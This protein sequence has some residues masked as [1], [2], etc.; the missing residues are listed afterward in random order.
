MMTPPLE[1]LV[2]RRFLFALAALTSLAA[3]GKKTEN[4]VAIQT[5]PVVRRDIVVDATATATI[6]PINIVEVKSKTASG[7]ITQMT[8]EVGSNVRPGDLIVQIDTR[9]LTNAANQ[10]QADFEAAQAK[11]NTSTA[12]KK[13]SD[14][15]FK[16][17]IITAQE[18]E[19]ANLDFA[20]SQA[21]FVRARTSLDL[22]QQRL[23][24][25]TVRAPVVGT[26]IE[27]TVSLGQVIQ[28]GTTSMGGGSTIL[29]MADLSRV[30]ARAL[31]NETDIGQIVAGQEATVTVDAFPDRPF[32]GRVEKV[33]PQAVVQQNVTMFPVLISLSN[34]EGLLKPGMNGEAAVLVDRRTDVL[35]IPNDAVRSMREVQTIAPL[36]NL[37]PDSVG[38]QLR[39]SMGAM[40]GGGRGG[41]GGARPAQG[42]RPQT[43]NGAVDLL[44]Q[45]FGGQGGGGFQ[46][47]EVTDADCKKVDD[48]LKK[49]PAVAKQL[50]ALREQMRNPDA[51]RRA[52]F[53]QT[54]E[55]YTKLGVDA[56]VAGACRRREGGSG[57][58][59]GGGAMAGGAQGGSRPGDAQARGSSSRGDQAG[60]QV[61]VPQGP[62]TRA[63]SRTGL[64]FVQKADSTWEPRM[65]RLGVAN[66]D[67]TEVLDGLK[68]GER[69]ALLSAAAMQ[70]QRQAANDRARQMMGGGSPLGGGAA[71]GR[72][73]GGGGPGGGGPGGGGSGGGGQSQ[74]GASSRPRN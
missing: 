20:N 46:Q 19:T 24:D 43:S 40:F 25:A 41:Q 21:S 2:N 47:V 22:A 4:T 74:G 15:L 67:H 54:Q 53:T 30:R 12:Q 38:A 56:R 45:G 39:A 50:D 29:K 73:P 66:F 31:V 11:L 42:G 18:N 23:E 32:R 13:R 17:R 36:L 68:E 51:D 34:E 26:V 48:A 5:A 52:L 61:E 7:Q 6:E 33:E 70:A 64:V 1:H 57:G 62:G 71:G 35:S 69:V 28:A 60:R 49:Q 72:M 16:Q 59:P 9:D 8:V 37:D 10:A 3:C 27:K 63:R 14:D 55:L 65:V 58:A 44:P